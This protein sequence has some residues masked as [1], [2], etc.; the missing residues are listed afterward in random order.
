MPIVNSVLIR[1]SD[2][3]VRTGPGSHRRLLW[4]ALVAF[5]LGL[6]SVGYL[7]LSLSGNTASLFEYSYLIPWILLVF[8]VVSIP[9]LYLVVRRSFE[10]FHPLVYAAWIYFIPAF[11]VGSLLF[12]T[13]VQ[14][15]WF[16]ELIPN[17]E[18]Y[19]PLTLIYIAL[20]FVG[21]TLGFVI[22]LGRRIG[23]AIGRQLPTWDWE[24]S[25]LFRPAMFLVIIGEISKLGAFA[26]M[27]LGF[28]YTEDASTFGAM[29]YM[30][31]LL[32]AMGSFLLWFA[33]FRAK[34]LTMRHYLIA[35]MLLALNVYSMVL[36]GGKGGLFS[37]TVLLIAAYL[38]SGRRIKLQQAMLVGL[39]IAGA[40]FFGVA[41][42]TAFRQIKGNESQMSLREYLSLGSVVSDQLG[43][44]GLTENLALS[45]DMLFRRMETVSQVAV[46]VANYEELHSAEASYGIA[47][48]W[49]MTR[50]A[51]I[52]RAFWP[53]KP[54]ISGA[55]GLGLLYFGSGSSSPAVT[56]MIDLLRNFGPIGILIGMA[57]LGVVLRI[58]YSALIHG[59]RTS[60]WRSVGYYLLLSNVSYESM[61]GSILPV[62]IRVCFVLLVGAV[63]L[64]VMMRRRVRVN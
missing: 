26:N 19:L 7:A 38:F 9:A 1:I 10:L 57:L 6:L 21:L 45:T 24:A 61:Y 2:S 48:I 15:S 37:N 29:L 39:L 63:I 41:F 12:A 40:L 64:N 28:Q 8:V 42:G 33:I 59:Q 18:R 25:D 3:M 60:A 44:Q 30:F 22:P 13:G 32:S 5:G 54:Y 47:D 53:E 62:L 23:G 49:T 31:G 16:V 52:P 35:L 14:T 55:R 58:V 51:F 36:G 43:R 20:G 56:P 34:R 11:V 17:P 4:V 50:T 46:F 27:N